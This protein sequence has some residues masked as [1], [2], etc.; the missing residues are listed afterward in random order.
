MEPTEHQIQQA[1]INY[2]K[3]Q[4]WYVQRMNSGK[5]AYEYKGRRKFLM[6]AERGTPDILA[7]KKTGDW[8]N[9]KPV[10]RI[11]FVEVKRP[12][13]KP[14]DLQ[15]MKMRELKEF[16]AECFVATS[17]EDLQTYRL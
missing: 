17:V 14:T 4:G 5:M 12:G 11:I 2:L 3:I 10:V 6:L 16:G 8:Y 9:Y 15:E 13:N 7:F 1:C